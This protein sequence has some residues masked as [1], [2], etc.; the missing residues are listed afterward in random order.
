MLR[1]PFPDHFPPPLSL[2]P[3]YVHRANEWMQQD[4]ENI[5]IIHCKVSPASSA[6]ETEEGA[7]FGFPSQAGKGRFVAAA[8]C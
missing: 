8:E 6:L 2:I 1:F 5:L 7:D 4:E 3:L